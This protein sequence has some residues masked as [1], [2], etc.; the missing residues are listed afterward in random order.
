MIYPPKLAAGSR[1]RVVTAASPVKPEFLQPGLAWL[2]ARGWI[3]EWDER[4]YRTEFYSAGT[5]RER[6]DE[7]AGA[8]GDPTAAAVWFARG[9]YGCGRLLPGLDRLAEDPPAPKAVVGCSDATFVLIHL[10]QRLE[11]VVFHG[12][13]VAGDIGRG[14]ASFDG[15]YLSALL[16]GR[17]IRAA[18]SPAPL[19][20]LAGGA[21]V[22]APLT[23]GCL[24]ILAATLGTPRE[25]RTDGRILFLEDTQLKPYQLDRLLIQLRQAGKL[26][27]CAGIVFGQLP[28]CLPPAGAAYDLPGALQH[29]LEGL[30]CPVLFGLPSGH[31]AAPSLPL[32]LGATYRLDPA[33]GNL[34]LEDAALCP[35]C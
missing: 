6:A 25:W 9:G 4:G 32:A 33:A 26:D 20:V 29:A 22:R 1:I 15:D 23:G 18:V 8:L 14:P 3:P 11:W 28:D 19:A 34:F 2:R 12:P 17:P 7:L 10:L 13:M 27:R 21:P 24:T 30:D 5:D 31:C 35:V 16:E